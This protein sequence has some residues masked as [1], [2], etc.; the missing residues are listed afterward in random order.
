MRNIFIATLT[1]LLLLPA[2][3]RAQTPTPAQTPTNDAGNVDQ[4]RKNSRIH[5][6]PLYI[7]PT[8][9]LKEIG[10]DSNVFNAAGEQKSD[11]TTTFTPQADIALTFARRALLKATVGSDLVYYQKYDTERSIDPQVKVR[12]EAYAHRLTL[13]AEGAY[14]N[15]RQRPNYEIDIRSRHVEQDAQAGAALRLTPKLSIE[16]AARR[17]EAR[18][19]ADAVI[20]GTN[21]RET[22]N[23]STEGLTGAVRHRLTPLTTLSVQFDRL[24]DTFTFSGVRNSRSFRVMPGV[25]FKPR[26]LVSG[27]AFVGYRKFTPDNPLILPQFSGLVA[28]LGLSYTLLG[29]TTFGVSYHRDLAYSYEVANP[30]FIDNSVGASI[31]RALVGRFDTIVSAD[32]HT[33]DYEQLLTLPAAALQRAD[34]TWVYGANIG[35]RIRRQ[36]R[37]G[38][39]ARYFTRDSTTVSLV[40]YDGLRLGATFDYGF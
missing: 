38:F 31:R 26:A 3:A 34:T 11:F 30:F 40:R 6:G 7:N 39:G 22:L 23:R 16:L 9:L 10:V 29:S 5:V 15:T 35:Y 8:L 32:R 21:L 1:S 13:F 25:E 37:I 27:S 19:D 4:I 24:A 14:L 17:A 12:A 2:A 28:D 18:Y 33:Y 20:A 36:A